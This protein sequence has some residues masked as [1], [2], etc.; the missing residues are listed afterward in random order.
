ML[1]IKLAAK[2][3]RQPDPDLHPSQHMKSNNKY[4]NIRNSLESSNSKSQSGDYNLIVK[5]NWNYNSHNGGMAQSQSELGFLK[6][7]QE[8]LPYVTGTNASLELSRK[9]FKYEFG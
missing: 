8:K 2:S 5:A 3:Q 4:L 6:L 9:S 7:P 1:D